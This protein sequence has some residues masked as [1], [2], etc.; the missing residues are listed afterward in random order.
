MVGTS[1][2]PGLPVPC[3]ARSIRCPGP[4][5]RATV[6]GRPSCRDPR[7]ARQPGGFLRLRLNLMG[8]VAG[9]A[10]TTGV[11]TGLDTGMAGC[12][13]RST[14]CGSLPAPRPDWRPGGPCRQARRPELATST[15]SGS[16]LP[17]SLSA[18][19]LTRQPGT[20]HQLTLRHRDRRVRHR[21]RQRHVDSTAALASPDHSA[22]GCRS[23]PPGNYGTLSERRWSTG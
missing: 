18:A 14:G 5:K 23:S 13:S 22:K 8:I 2:D 10:C 9:G 4:V 6:P 19:V 11:Q 20:W 15:I 7:H 3:A 16:P 21:H 1:L 17:P 12:G